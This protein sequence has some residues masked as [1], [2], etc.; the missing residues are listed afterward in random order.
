MSNSKIFL[1]SLS[2]IILCLINCG[3][4]K[5]TIPVGSE[6]II[7][8]PR[9]EFGDATFFFYEHGIRR[10]RL[11]ADYMSRPLADT[12]KLIVVPV[13]IMVYDSLGKPA[14]RIVAD[15]GSTDS[16]MEQFDLWGSV[17]IKTEEGMVVKSEQLRWFKEER[18]VTSDTHVQI[19]TPKGDLLRGRGLDAT[20]N[21]SRFSFKADVRG[22][23]PD[24]RRRIEEEDDFFKF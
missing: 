15:S 5:D 24:F 7:T 13:Q 18:R 8:E 20:D 21:F 3:P 6:D 10:W 1:F 9:Q 19:E 16:R 23:F 17:L 2:F 4:Q 22:K 12:G 11:D 14:T